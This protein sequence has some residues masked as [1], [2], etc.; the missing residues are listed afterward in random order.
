MITNINRASAYWVGSN[1][2]GMGLYLYFASML[3]PL[4]EDAGTDLAGTPII[5]GLTVFRVLAVCSLINIVWLTL[6]VRGGLRGKGWRSMR[7][8]LLVVISWV[9]VNRLDFYN[10]EHGST[11]RIPSPSAWMHSDRK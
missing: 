6:I 2:I 3:W 4:P 9:A 11:F 1:M 5:W 10:I 7:V 8:W